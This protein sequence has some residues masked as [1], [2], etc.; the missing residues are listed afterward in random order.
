MSIEQCGLEGIAAV[1]AAVGTLLL[2]ALAIWGDW[3]RSVLAPP[4]LK[5]VGH[6]LKG[7]RTELRVQGAAHPTGGIPVMYYHLKVVNLRPRITVQNC[8]VLLK[9]ISRRG[10]DNIFRPEPMAVPFQFIWARETDP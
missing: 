6:T 2:G 7:E 4:K 9:G 8:Q 5:L 1:I 10:P 3:I